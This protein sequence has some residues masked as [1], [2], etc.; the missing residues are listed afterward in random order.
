MSIFSENIRLLRGRKGY[1]QQKIADD[2]IIT[3]AR[4][5]KYEEG[6]SEPP[7]DVLKRIS[8]YFHVSIDI[9][10]SVDLRKIS[11]DDLLKLDDNRILFPITVDKQGKDNIEIVPHKAKAGYLTSYSDPEFIEGLQQ[12]R[13]PMLGSGKHRAF[14]IDGDSMPPHRPSS[15]VVGRY[16]EKIAD[17]KDGKTYIIL[18][19]SEGI[20]YKRAYK[21]NKKENTLLLYSDNKFYSP[22]EI[23]PTE[24][25][26]IWEYA[27]SFTMKEYEPDD[28]SS[29]SVREMFRSIRTEL[30]EVK[31]KLAER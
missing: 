5:S 2:L 29:E 16:V 14:P 3:R 22:Y 28:L 4:L 25:L 8:K 27:C 13:I 11:L 17:V 12:M 30:N 21:K 9:L 24:V 19:R 26:E 15:F 1:S 10:I 23:K 7:L 20:I 31:T 6:K 18:S